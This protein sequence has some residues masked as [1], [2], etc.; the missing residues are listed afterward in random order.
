MI[1]KHKLALKNMNLLFIDDDERTICEA[2]DVF[3]MYFNDV[4]IAKDGI[5]ALNIY[6][7]NNIDFIITDIVIPKI[8][9]IELIEQIRKINRKIPIIILSAYSDKELLLKAANLQIDGYI[10]KPISFKKLTASF[11]NALQ[12]IQA[13]SI[14]HINN[15][16]H[17]NLNTM[18]LF[19]NQELLTL[20]MKEN[21][22]LGYLIINND[23]MVSKNELMVNVWKY[24]YPTDSAFK[25]LIYN[26]RKKVGKDVI[27][28]VHGIGWK[29]KFN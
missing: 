19:K 27:E 8:E 1:E 28:N 24:D 10:V 13:L 29:I 11:D 18:Q 20:G 3:F 4:F 23:R 17:Y 25:N 22:F 15:E 16:L 6:N 9:G 2:Q 21:Q 5:S 14:I 26:I 12:R 7:E